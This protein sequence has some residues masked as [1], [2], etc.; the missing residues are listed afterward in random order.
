LV[1]VR[2]LEFTRRVR[3]KSE[4]IEQ[5]LLNFVSLSTAQ[6]TIPEESLQ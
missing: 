4:F 5:V 2:N 3:S 6:F 1:T